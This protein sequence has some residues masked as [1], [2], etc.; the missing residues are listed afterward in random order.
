MV[1]L[2]IE[3]GPVGDNQDQFWEPRHGDEA[4]ITLP[5]TIPSLAEYY[6]KLPSLSHVVETTKVGLPV[7]QQ[8]SSVL[9]ALSPELIYLIIEYL[10]MSCVNSL[11]AA[12]GYVAQLPLNS[13]FWRK[14][15]NRDQ[16][17]LYDLPE[18]QDSNSVD[19]AQTYKDL[20][21]RSEES[22]DGHIR[23]LVNRRRIWDLCDQISETYLETKE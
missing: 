10:D 3:Y 2:D 12:S 22:F 4:Y 21:R 6:E 1:T 17:W 8:N 14:R 20:L 23:G 16:P 7:R 5:T 9:D 19:W 15:I 13:A 11:R 18:D